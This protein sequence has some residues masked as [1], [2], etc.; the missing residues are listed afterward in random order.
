MSDPGPPR[1]IV[2]VPAYNEAECLPTV[3][4]ELAAVVPQLDIVVVDDGSAD[5]TS[6]VARAK[7]VPCI[8]LPFNLGIGGA[9]RA[10]YRYAHEGGWDRAI[11]FDGDGQHR[12]DQIPHLLD[13]LDQGTE[14]AIGNRF[15]GGEYTVGRSRRIAMSVLRVG[16]SLLCRRRFTDT[17][18]GFRGVSQPLLGVFAT[19][20]PVEYMD[21]VETLV[22]ACRAGYTVE[23]VPVSMKPRQAGIPSTG[24]IRLVYHYARLLVVLAGSSRRSIPA[25]R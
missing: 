24:R 17:T 2:V 9:L 3:L 14:L 13:R 10:G 7:G 1:T 15:A 8:R 5:A 4:D 6:G 22:A 25:R 19:E 20:Y 12:A 21:S 16:V 18:S 11:Q 23:E